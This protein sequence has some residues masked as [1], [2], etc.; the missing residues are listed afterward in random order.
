MS[1]T[2]RKRLVEHTQAAFQCSQRRAC[3]ALGFARSSIRYKHRLE[4]RDRALATE[5]HKLSR[6]FPRYGYRR[7]WAELDRSGWNVTPKRVLRVWRKEGLKVPQKQ[8]KKRALGHS[9]NSCLLLR[10]TRPNEIWSVDFVQ[11]TAANGKMLKI[12]PVVDEFTRECVALE[13]DYTM[14]SMDVKQILKRLFQER[15]TP[16][17]VRSDN[18]PE[19]IAKALQ[20]ALE[21]LGCESRFIKPGSPWENG[22]VESFNSRLRDEVLN[23]EM[24]W[25]ALEAKVVLEEFQWFHN[26]ER[27]HSSLNYQTPEEFAR[28]FVKSES[29]HA[30]PSRPGP[31]CGWPS[32]SLDRTA[33]AIQ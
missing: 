14:T 26:E 11:D 15:G 17:Y 10:P 25:S 29:A 22:V 13:V 28:S 30:N 4:Q 8:K 33:E 3:R 20:A 23:R 2:S 24:F 5:L 16:Q 21:E 27:P 12:L 1:P 7:I 6:R 31:P 18:G 32:A 9:R 19:F